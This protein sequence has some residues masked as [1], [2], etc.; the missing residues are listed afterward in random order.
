MIMQLLAWAVASAAS[1]AAAATVSATVLATVSVTPPPC[2]GSDPAACPYYW[3][4][5]NDTF[6]TLYV[7]GR[8][9]FVY[10]GEDP[11]ECSGGYKAQPGHC[12]ANWNVQSQSYTMASVAGV[13]AGA[14]V[15]VR[16]VTSRGRLAG[17]PF[18]SPRVVSGFGQG[19]PNAATSATP[20]EYVFTVASAGHYSI[21]LF[22]G[23]AGL[24]DALLLFLDD[25]LGPAASG[26]PAPTGGGTLHHFTGPNTPNP[27]NP[28]WAHTGYYAFDTLTVSA[29]DVVCV[30]RGAWVEGHLQQQ[31]AGAGCTGHGIR[32]AG[33]GVW[34]GQSVLGK[35]PADDRRPLIQL[36]GANI[37][38]TGIVVANS[39]GANVELTPYWHRGYDD[40]AP[41]RMREARGGNRIDD[42]KVLATWWYSTDGLCVNEPTWAAHV[43]P[44]WVVFPLGGL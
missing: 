8:E 13:G 17:K 36:C 35:T 5:A 16:V 25:G 9:S 33:G 24:R 40:F 37:T 18:R 43:L 21:E 20:G 23:G 32:V 27:A 42:V 19:Q 30:D 7:N 2:D 34:S 28:S 10:Q 29:G 39:L 4:P 1:A 31:S 3:H 38:V 22:G 26:C 6:Y 11:P 44:A 12:A 15:K 41:G 14:P